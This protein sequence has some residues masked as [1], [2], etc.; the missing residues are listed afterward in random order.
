MRYTAAN[1]LLLEETPQAEPPSTPPRHVVATGVGAG[2]GFDLNEELW[3]QGVYAERLILEGMFVLV[4]DDDELVDPPTPTA[5]DPV[6]R[7]RRQIKDSK[8]VDGTVL[9]NPTLYPPLPRGDVQVLVN[10]VVQPVIDEPEAEPVPVQVQVPAPMDP[11]AGTG[12][13]PPPAARGQQR[14]RRT[15]RGTI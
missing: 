12:M 2:M 8:E 6:T 10:G 13:P 5:E 14:P 15:T 7:R 11:G 9:M 4:D 3:V 1:P